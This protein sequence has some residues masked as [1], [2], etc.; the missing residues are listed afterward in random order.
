MSSKN[1]KP[2]CTSPSKDK[3]NNLLLHNPNPHS[4]STLINLSSFKIDP[5]SL[6]LLDKGFN[7]SIA[8]KH[9]P[10][11]DI[12]R[13]IKLFAHHLPTHEVGEIG[14][15]CG[16]ILYFSKPPKPNL[17][18]GEFKSISLL[19]NN[20]NI[21]LLKVHKGNTTLI[22]NTLD[23]EFKFIDLLSS[24][25]YKI[26]T[27]NPLNTITSLITKSIKYSSLDPKIQKK[28]IPHNPNTLR[29][30]GQPK[31]HKKYIPLQPI[32]SVIGAPTYFIS[33]FLVSKLKT[34]TGKTSSLIKD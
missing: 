13:S 31:L 24:S 6:K 16:R 19:N 12:I 18:K 28:L 7:F 32:F 25:S 33:H 20:P 14:Q 9:N 8:P 2:W 30:Y 22:M 17:K 3:I 21:I 29:I 34:F 5:P 10:N 4:H 26:L 23:Y 15:D 1:P 11:E 27:K